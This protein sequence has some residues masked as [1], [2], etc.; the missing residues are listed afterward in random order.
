ML[1]NFL[2]RHY[3]VIPNNL[4]FLP[5]KEQRFSYG[6]HLTVSK[7]DVYFEKNSN[8]LFFQKKAIDKFPLVADTHVNFTLI[9]YFHYDVLYT[10]LI[11]YVCYYVHYDLKNKFS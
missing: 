10:V 6:L 7:L 11:L 5:E 4:F 3:I 8:S 9:Q 2:I 1:S